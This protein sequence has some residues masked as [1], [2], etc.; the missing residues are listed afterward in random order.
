MNYTRKIFYS[1]SPN[2]DRDL[3]AQAFSLCVG[4]K[5]QLQERGERTEENQPEPAK[6]Q[7]DTHTFVSP[8]TLLSVAPIS[9]L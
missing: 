8:A 5:A 3:P 7:N 2:N 9:E 6:E 1:P 4:K